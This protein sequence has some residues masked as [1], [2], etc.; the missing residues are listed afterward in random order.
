MKKNEIILVTG[1][2]GR[3]GRFIIPR[4][5][6]LGYKIRA[7]ARDNKNIFK[8][9]ENM[10]I[11]NIDSTT[12]WHQALLDVHTVIHLAAKNQPFFDF[13]YFSRNVFNTNVLGTENLLD[14]C[15]KANV[16][17]FI[18]LG[19]CSVYGP[20][21]EIGKAFDVFSK[22]NPVDTY[23]KSKVLAEDIIKFKLLNSKCSFKIIRIPYVFF[24][25]S[26][27]NSILFKCV[28]NLT[29][30]ISLPIDLKKNKRSIIV[31]NDLF[32]ALLTSI[33]EKEGCSKIILVRSSP[34]ISSFDILKKRFNLRSCKFS[35]YPL[36]LLNG[37]KKV[38]LVKK[39]TYKLI[40]NFQ[41]IN[42][43]KSKF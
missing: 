27:N 20:Y 24:N 40:C 42:S 25:Y 19:S 8:N 30:F 9:C 5:V 14:Q 33:R 34:D 37:L 16:K 29:K 28:I 41:I 6:G 10:V 11:G 38:P 35:S 15:I 26:Q 13:K 31:P 32:L 3:I 12:H 4:L 22:F 23:S 43:S 21:S 1:S 17:N 18:F 36:F 2:N 39:Y 7:A